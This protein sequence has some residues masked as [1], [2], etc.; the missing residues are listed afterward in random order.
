MVHLVDDL[1]GSEAGETMSFPLDTK[2]YVID[3]S[4]LNAAKLR[5][6][7]APF[8]A[9]ARRSGGGR[10][11]AIRSTMTDTSQRRKS[12]ELWD[13]LWA[14]VWVPESRRTFTRPADIADEPAEAVPRRRSLW[15]LVIARW[16]NGREGGA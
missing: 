4:D 10:K 8:V 11:S 9:A 16:W 12:A 6:A 5:D 3:L 15:I 1:D 14:N 7:L 13:W 2:D